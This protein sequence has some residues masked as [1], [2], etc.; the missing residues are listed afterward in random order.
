MKT[1]SATDA[2]FLAVLLGTLV[3]SMADSNLA[4][5]VDACSAPSGSTSIVILSNSDTY[6]SIPYARAPLY[7]GTILS[8]SNSTLT[9]QGAPGWSTGQWSQLTTNGYFPNYVVLTSGAKE[10]A[11]FT[12]TNNSSDSLEA[13][14]L[15]DLSGVVTGDQLAIIP[16][17]S[18]GTAFP[19]G[20]GITPSTSAIA[21]G[22]RTQLFSLDAHTY[23]GLNPNQ[24]FFFFNNAWRR[25]GSAATSN[26]NDV[27]ILPERNFI[28]RQNF[29]GATNVTFTAAGNVAEYSVRIYLEQA[30]TNTFTGDNYVGNY[31]STTQT[32]NQSNLAAI[33]SASD[34]GASPPVLNDLLLVY[35]NAAAAINK[36]PAH[37]YFYYNGHWADLSNPPYTVD[38]GADPVFIPGGGVTVRKKLGSGSSIWVIPP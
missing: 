10:G 19:G 37:I 28:L 23:S 11:T 13:V 25:V 34:P 12:V 15:E 27:V 6:V 18:L 9:V 1:T 17:W 38:R 22:R 5:A 2:G 33:L 14:G 32:L 36:T 24:V 26:Y 29:S 20:A 7:C 8:I 31:H 30:I 21:A 3:L 4:L 35:D 16:Y